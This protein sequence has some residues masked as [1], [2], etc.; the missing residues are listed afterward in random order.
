M[1]SQYV[2]AV[3]EEMTSTLSVVIHSAVADEEEAI[4]S[5][6]GAT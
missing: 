1:A 2:V 6:R 5:T 3:V 4:T